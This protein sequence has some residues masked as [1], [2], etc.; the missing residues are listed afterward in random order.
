MFYRM[1]EGVT[2]GEMWQTF[3]AEA[4]RR[5]EERKGGELKITNA[6]LKIE[7]TESG[8]GLGE[9]ESGSEVEAAD[10]ELV[11]QDLKFDIGREKECKGILT[12]TGIG[13]SPAGFAVSRITRTMAHGMGVKIY[14]ANTREEIEPDQAREQALDK[15]AY[16]QNYECAF[17]DENLTLLS[18]ELISAAER[19]T[20]DGKPVGFICEQDWSPAALALMREASGRLYVGFDVGRKVDLSV[21]TV[22]EDWGGLKVARGILRMQNLRLPE[23]Q[24]RLGEICRMAKFRRAAIDMTGLGLGLFDTRRRSLG[25]RKSRA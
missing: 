1:T 21:V 12:G 20:L 13:R 5:G 4:R 17:A 2:A 8:G 7:G 16:D 3:T 25:R 23:Q 19:R 22:M 6:K 14:D 18:H 15:R 10:C 9:E 11:V 24:E